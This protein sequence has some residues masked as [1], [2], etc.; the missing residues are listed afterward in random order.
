MRHPFLCRPMT[1]T[2]KRRNQE[3]AL[4]VRRVDVTASEAE[5]IALE[6]PSLF[7]VRT[8]ATPG[9]GQVGENVSCAQDIPAVSKQGGSVAKLCN[10][11]HGKQT[12][13]MSP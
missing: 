9:S 5:C 8:L 10:L 11:L 3:H 4:I 13:Y 2:V 1:S 7:F 12:A 6:W